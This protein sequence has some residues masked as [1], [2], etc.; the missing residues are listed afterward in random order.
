MSQAGLRQHGIPANQGVSASRREDEKRIDLV[1]DALGV[2]QPKEGID[3]P[4][5]SLQL[6]LRRS[7]GPG[8]IKHLIPECEQLWSMSERRHRQL[9]GIE[10]GGQCRRVSG[11]R[12]QRE[13]AIDLDLSLL[14]V[15]PMM[16]RDGELTV[17]AGAKGGFSLIDSDQR[18]AAHLL[19]RRSCRGIGH[20][21]DYECCRRQEVRSSD[22]TCK[23]AGLHRRVGAGPKR[24]RSEMRLGVSEALATTC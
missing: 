5:P 23:L 20:A 10:P 12:C 1:T 15:T 14:G 22:L 9:L 8:Y 17:K 24:S 4:V 16:E 3:L 11:L 7:Q 21:K 13:R 6:D 2:T 19:D 18:G